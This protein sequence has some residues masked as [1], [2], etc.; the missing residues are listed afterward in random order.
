M[1]IPATFEVLFY[2]SYPT[3]I[4]TE[5][6]LDVLFSRGQ[7]RQQWHCHRS[8]LYQWA[9]SI[10][11]SMFI[12]VMIYCSSILFISGVYLHILYYVAHLPMLERYRRKRQ[13]ALFRRIPILLLM[14]ILPALVYLILIVYRSWRHSIPS[15]SFR[16]IVFAESIGQAG[17]VL[18]IFISNT[19]FRRHC[20]QRR[21]T[22][23]KLT[24]PVKSQPNGSEFVSLSQSKRIIVIK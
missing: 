8:L 16:L 17:A 15:F 22:N 13:L 18:T 4:K 11:P 6:V 19:R 20:Y 14:I 21:T 23:K 3:T 12:V 5:L 2:S 1:H 24:K 10:V 9:E 7:R